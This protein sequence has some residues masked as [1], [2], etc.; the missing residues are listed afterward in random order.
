MEHGCA[1]DVD[2]ALR[3]YFFS[4]FLS[5]VSRSAE[6]SVVLDIAIIL[7]LKEILD[8]PHADKASN[9]TYSSTAIYTL[10]TSA[11]EA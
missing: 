1:R 9:E 10:F 7:G 6:R 4:N 8:P 11:D 2:F 3:F 5:K